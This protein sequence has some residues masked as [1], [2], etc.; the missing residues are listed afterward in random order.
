MA[1]Y[2]EMKRIW[3][4]EYMRERIKTIYEVTSACSV[5]QRYRFALWLS[6]VIFE[7]LDWQLDVSGCELNDVTSS[8]AD[9]PIAKHTSQ[10]P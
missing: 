1:G 6:F 10:I 4:V 2:F 8:Y 7:L 5:L 9:E 3:G